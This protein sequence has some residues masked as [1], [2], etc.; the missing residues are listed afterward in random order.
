MG[1]AAVPAESIDNAETVAAPVGMLSA[2][3][4]GA[5][6][7]NAK[8][9]GSRGSGAIS[10]AA[11]G[12][13]RLVEGGSLHLSSE[14]RDILQRR[15]LL[16]AAL[17]TFGYV[18]FLVR[19][20]LYWDQ[21]F[22]TAAG[23]MLV[24]YAQV[25]ATLFTGLIALGLA[26]SKRLTLAP[27]RIAEWS[28][29]GVAAAFFTLITQHRLHA[30]ANM[31]MGSHL[32]V[33]VGPWLLL[34]FIYAL[35]IPNTWRRALRF[36]LPAA[37]LPIAV[38]Y[39]QKTVCTGFQACLSRGG[40]G[41]Y[42]TEQ[43]LEMLFALFIAVVGVYTI[44]T[45]R[46]EAFAA[47][48]LGQYRL[49]QLLGSGGMGE[50]YLAEHQMMKRPCAIKVIRPDKAGDKRN[51]AR[52]EREVR[53]TAKLSHWNS[54]DIYD[55]GRTD[56]GTFYYVMEY[57]PGHNLGELIEQEGA[58]PAA[59][60]VYLMDQVCRALS[61]AH[62]IGLVHRDIKPANIFCSYRGGEF[63]VAK[64]LDFGLAKPTGV[65]TEGTA[66]AFLTQEGAIT[67]SPM[68][69][70]PE[71]ATGEREADARSDIY[72]LGCVLYY[73]LTGKSPFPYEQVVKVIIAHASEEVVTP[74]EHNPLLAIELEEVILRCL[75]KDP[76]D[77]F[78]TVEQLRRALVDVQLDDEW[79][80]ERAADWWNCKA[81]PE[82]KAMAAAAIEAAAV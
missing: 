22:S 81:C 54:I 82:R 8:D 29:F 24:F 60:V 28:I 42:I 70:S 38:I 40:Y 45:L 55:Y 47:K 27:L 77:R 30:A 61:E 79:S 26:R 9:S 17:F 65:E 5:N 63:D 44:N 69:M 36:L 20:L 67:G 39:F 66:G 35:F 49:K 12:L 72:S 33:V 52:F 7:S 50:V 19:G 51:M 11:R 58:L 53:S 16:A 37:A 1:A 14:T 21:T 68:F 2:I 43:A 23:G 3:R 78:Q 13:V 18:A 62:G 71:Q 59:R 74:R 57:L 76:E 6:A 73:L 48:Q 41:D 10:A 80:P 32:P 75:E 46:R 34:I 25:A 31:E 15:L 56:D 64:L 4:A